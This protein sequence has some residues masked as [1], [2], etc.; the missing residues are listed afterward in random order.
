M[1]RKHQQQSPVVL[2]AVVALHAAALGALLHYQP[3][4]SAAAAD[5]M[6]VSLIS[7]PTPAP[8]VQPPVPPKPR[9]RPKPVEKTVTPP[10]PL[11]PPS[12]TA[13]SAPPAPPEPPAEVV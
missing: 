13:I 4:V 7:A 11:E 9:V 6:R 5:I 1:A 2:V 8:V 12:E 3:R 10:A